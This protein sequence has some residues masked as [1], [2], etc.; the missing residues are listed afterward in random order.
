MDESAPDTLGERAI[1]FSLA[2]HIR[3]T[4]PLSWPMRPI[5]SSYQALA[6]MVFQSAW[7]SP[8]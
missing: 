4:A 7:Y 5:H 8:R 1:S 6:P 2:F 3:A